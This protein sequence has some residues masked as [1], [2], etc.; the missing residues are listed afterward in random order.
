MAAMAK[1]RKFCK[2]INKQSS[3]RKQLSQWD[4][5]FVEWSLDGPLSELYPMTLSTDQDGRHY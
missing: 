2:K 4:K 1:N 3:P 5:T